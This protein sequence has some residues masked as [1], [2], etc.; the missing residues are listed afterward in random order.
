MKQEEMAA[1]LCEVGPGRKVKATDRIEKRKEEQ[2][3]EIWRIDS[4]KASLKKCRPVRMTGEAEVNTKA[5]YNKENRDS[6][7]S[8]C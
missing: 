2:G 5:A 3:N 6:D 7:S 1:K 4:K 8:D